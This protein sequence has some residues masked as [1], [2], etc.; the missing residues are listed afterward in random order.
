MASAADRS[1]SHAASGPRGGPI[2]ASDVAERRQSAR[3]GPQAWFCSRKL[4]SGT[5]Q[6][7]AELI[8]QPIQFAFLLDL[9]QDVAEPE[10]ADF[11]R[12]YSAATSQSEVMAIATS[13]VNVGG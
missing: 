9:L 12:M 8:Y 10:V 3:S 7:S 11:Q 13:S 2:S 4:T 6:I 1:G 5:Y